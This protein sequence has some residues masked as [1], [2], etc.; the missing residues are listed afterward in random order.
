M[1]NA[2]K[3]LLYLWTETITIAVYFKNYYIKNWI[4][5]VNN[6]GQILFITE[7]ETL[8]ELIPYEK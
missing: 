8:E 7:L 6:Y 4:A 3:S 2:K 5:T 1:L